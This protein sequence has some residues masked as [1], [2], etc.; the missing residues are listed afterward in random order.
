MSRPFFHSPSTMNRGLKNNLRNAPNLSVFQANFYAARMVGS[1][2]QYILNNTPC[3]FSRALIFFKDDV[4]FKTRV[5]IASV[6]SVHNIDELRKSCAIS[7]R[8][9]LFAQI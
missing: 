7:D 4:Y 2:G 8:Q 5:D 9:Q 1:A 6:S 3:K